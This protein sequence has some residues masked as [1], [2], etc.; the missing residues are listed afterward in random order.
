MRPRLAPVAVA[1]ILAAGT[2]VADPANVTKVEILRTGDSYRF[3]VTVRHDGETPEHFADRWEILLTNGTVIG[4]RVLLQPHPNEQ[5]FT[6]SLGGVR[7]PEGERSVKVRAHETA[8]G[9]G[10]EVTVTMPR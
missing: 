6:R 1:A 5:P 10:K 9:F 2:A 7:V 8:N 3:D 4:T